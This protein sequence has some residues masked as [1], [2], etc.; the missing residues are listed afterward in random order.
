MWSWQSL[1]DLGSFLCCLLGFI[2]ILIPCYS[3]RVPSQ[4]ASCQMLP[5]CLKCCMSGPMRVGFKKQIISSH[6]K[7]IH[8]G[9][10]H[11]RIWGREFRS[12]LQWK[13]LTCF[14]KWE[15]ERNFVSL[16]WYSNE[17]ET[18]NRSFSWNKVAE[19]EDYCP[20]NDPDCT[21]GK[22]PDI[23]YS[24]QPVC[25]STVSE[26]YLLSAGGTK[27]CFICDLISNLRGFRL[28]VA[29]LCLVLFVFWTWSVIVRGIKRSDFVTGRNLGLT[30]GFIMALWL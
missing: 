22:T 17:L 30:L 8:G 11:Q 29:I 3:I 27:G 25:L 15:K 28:V 5:V 6:I 16:T 19:I 21:R 1:T 18:L 20:S 13:P 14:T 23:L 4:V 7:E 10:P 12:F 24:L 2:V 9:F 26:K